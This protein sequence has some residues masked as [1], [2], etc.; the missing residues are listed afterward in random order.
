MAELSPQAAARLARDIYGLV[1]RPSID[2]AIREIAAEYG[3]ELDV[4][5]EVLVAAKTGGPG[6]I[7]SRTAF[8][9]CCFGKGIYKGHAFI[10][11]RGTRFLGD[12]LTN[13][14]VGTARSSYGQSI[15][16]GFQASFASLQP[17]IQN[18]V[19]GFGQQGIHSV[20]CI[21]HS[22]GG[23][24]ATLCAE[25]IQHLGYQPYVY[26][27]GAPRVG[28]AGFA[29]M[30]T[31]KLQPERIFRV[32]HRTDIVPCVPFWPFVHAPTLLSDTYDYFQPSPGEFP[33]GKWHDMGLYVETVGVK[34]W[35]AL[36]GKRNHRIHGPSIE[37]WVNKKGPVSFNVSNL[38]WLDKAISYVVSRLFRHI[39][40]S[41]LLAASSTFTLMDRL[42]Y[43]L[44][45]GIN[46]AANMSALVLGLI[47]KIML[48]LGLKPLVDAAEA[49]HQFIRNLF[50]RLAKQVNSYCRRVIDYALVGGK[51]V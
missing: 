36:R 11:L 7:K 33:S 49:T 19:S 28:M 50:E 32:Y 22:L 42:A 35:A 27:F 16:A 4:S 3:N 37:A 47:R 2:W 51:A 17:K 23:G 14:N 1:N 21:G 15:H 18:F 20:H 6:F 29:D 5:K 13:A 41:V 24:L 44:K 43:I 39:G 30:L 10:V 26:S 9:L 8:G 25:Y 34:K 46:L 40:S 45:Q 31:S 38:E 48:M 12:W